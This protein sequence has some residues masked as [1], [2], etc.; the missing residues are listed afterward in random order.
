MCGLA[1]HDDLDSAQGEC[2]G[3][4][5]GSEV[6]YIE[7]LSDSRLEYS[8]DLGYYFEHSAPG[9]LDCVLIFKVCDVSSLNKSLV[10]QYF[11]ITGSVHFSIYDIDYEFIS[12]LP[13]VA[14]IFAIKDLCFY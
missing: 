11:S 5:V 6:G 12:K 3:H 7:S 13:Q 2:L 9:T 10:R 14:K 1:L 8:D 4:G